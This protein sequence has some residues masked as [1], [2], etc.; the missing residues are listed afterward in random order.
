MLT[1]FMQLILH[2]I[3]EVLTTSLLTSY[4][5]SAT[6]LHARVPFNNKLVQKINKRIQLQCIAS[7]TSPVY[8]EVEIKASSTSARW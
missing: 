6:R 2:V 3:E 1:I 8:K 5:Q 7:C 4:T